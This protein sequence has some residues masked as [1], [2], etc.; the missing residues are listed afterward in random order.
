MG[1]E[2]F[3]REAIAMATTNVANGG[4]PFGAIVVKNGKVI[5]RRKSRD[6]Q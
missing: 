1:N 4:G 6:C 3:M 2:D 5:G